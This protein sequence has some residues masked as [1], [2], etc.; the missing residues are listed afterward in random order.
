MKQLGLSFYYHHCRLHPCSTL[1]NSLNLNSPVAMIR[2]RLLM[3]HDLVYL[4]E[5][6][7]KLFGP[8]IGPVLYS[9]LGL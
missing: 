3:Q 7:G 8:G 1:L 2:C 6:G 9:S 5:N 4:K